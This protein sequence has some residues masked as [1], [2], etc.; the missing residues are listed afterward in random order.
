M[1][2]SSAFPSL[3]PH[4]VDLKTLHLHDVELKLPADRYYWHL[5]KLQTLFMSAVSVTASDDELISARPLFTPFTLPALTKLAWTWDEDNT[6]P[7]LQLGHQLTHLFLHRTPITTASNPA[8]RYPALPDSLLPS[9][10][11]IQ[12]LFFTIRYL[13]D[14]PPLGS[15]PSFLHSLHLSFFPGSE[16]QVEPHLVQT[17][18]KPRCLDQAAVLFIPPVRKQQMEHDEEGKAVEPEWRVK[19][20]QWAG[21]TSLYEVEMKMDAQDTMDTDAKRWLHHV[22]QV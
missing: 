14:I 17:G 19:T 22:S 16:R 5:P 20:R 21:A 1:S 10:T 9:L 6:G 11:S 4:P 7:E 12:H 15:I 3:I 2:S 8:P 18:P 13:S